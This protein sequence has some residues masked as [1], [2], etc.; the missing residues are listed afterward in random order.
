MVVP[1]RR[2]GGYGFN[3]VEGIGNL[4]EVPS[5]QM[6]VDGGRLGTGMPQKTLNM[7]QVRPVFQQMGGKAVAQ[8]MYADCFFDAGPYQRFFEG[9]LDTRYGKRY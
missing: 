1:L 9:F 6:E 2:A 3:D 4:S 7:V 5:T 8:C